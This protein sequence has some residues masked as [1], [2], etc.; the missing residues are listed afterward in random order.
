MGGAGGA[1]GAPAPV[2]FSMPCANLAVAA[3]QIGPGQTAAALTTAELTGTE[4]VWDNYVELFPS[5]RI[6]CRYDLPSGVTPARVTSLSLQVNYRGPRIAFQ[7]WTFEAFDTGTGAWVQI[8]DNGFAPSWVWTPATFPMP[9]PL[10]RFFSGNSLQAR[11]G[12][13]SNFDAAN[14]D[15][16]IVTGLRAP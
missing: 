14:I 1:G 4:D 15:Q 3:G 12:T 6:V 11:F 5:S 2:P 13:G 8:G 10:A 9:A 16:M 7:V